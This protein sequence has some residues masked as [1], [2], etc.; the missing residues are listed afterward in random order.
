MLRRAMLTAAILCGVAS[1]PAL[2]Q[3][4]TSFT[5]TNRSNAVVN[6]VYF[7]PTRLT[8]WGPDRLGQNVLAPGSSVNF[9]PSPGGNYDFKIVFANGREIERRSVDLCS[10]STVTV[11]GS[12]IAVQ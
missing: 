4:D 2:A 9:R 5:L 8:N 6:E 10:V 1:A 11:S 12:G 3:C 7:N